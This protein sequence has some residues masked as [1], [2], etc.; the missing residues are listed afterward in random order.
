MLV[1]NFWH[2]AAVLGTNVALANVPI[3]RVLRIQAGAGPKVMQFYALPAK[4]HQHT[5]H[6]KTELPHNH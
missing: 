1:E 5:Q 4:D 6:K 2:Q 3:M